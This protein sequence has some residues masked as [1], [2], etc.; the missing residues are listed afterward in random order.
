[1]V[2]K[3]NF[4]ILNLEQHMHILDLKY[5]RDKQLNIISLNDIFQF[6]FVH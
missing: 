2:V 1:M 4:G 3:R 5:K 6:A